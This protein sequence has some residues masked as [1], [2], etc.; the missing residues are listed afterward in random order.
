M[1]KEEEKE[2]TIE[3]ILKKISDEYN[4]MKSIDFEIN[5]K[6]NTINTQ[7]ATSKQVI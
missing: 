5:E 3:D 2:E 7:N 6:D 4:K 1:K